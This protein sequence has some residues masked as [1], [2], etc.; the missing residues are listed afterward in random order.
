MTVEQ[1]S[2]IDAIGT[3]RTSGAVHLTIADH[4]EW[5]REH[6]VMLQDKLNTYLAFVESGEIYSAYPDATG[7]NVVIDVVL[8]HRPNDEAASFLEKIRSLIEQAGFSF[9]YGPISVGYA[10]DNG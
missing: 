6:M 2:V 5:N 7:R 3:D 9:H 4:L 1:A 10:C 8:K